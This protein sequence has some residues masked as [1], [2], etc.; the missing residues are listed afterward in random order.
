M[1]RL[2]FLLCLITFHLVIGAQTVNYYQKGNITTD[3]ITIEESVVKSTYVAPESSPFSF[4]NLTSKGLD[5]TTSAVEPA[6][7]LQNT[8]GVNMYSDNGTNLGYMYYRLRGIDQSRINTTLNGVPMNEPED[9]GIYFNNYPGF[10]QSVSSLQVIRG[11]GISKSGI[12][13]YGGSMNFQ[14]NPFGKEFGGDVNTSLGSYNTYQGSVSISDNNYYIRA[15]GVHTD[16]YKQNTF[17]NGKSMFYG[18]KFNNFKI[19]G[20][21]GDQQNGMGWLGETKEDLDLDPSFNSNKIHEQDDFTYVHN[22]LNYTNGNFSGT[23][24]HTYLNGWYDTD[25]AHFVPEL[26][27]GAVISRI[28]LESHWFGANLDYYIRGINGINAHLGISGST[29]FRDHVGSTNN[30]EDYT[31]TG[32]KKDLAPY[33]KMD[34]K[35]N[36]VLLYFDAQYRYTEFTYDGLTEFERKQYHFINWSGGATYFTGDNSNVYFGLGKTHR[37]PT[38]TD[39]FAGNDDFIPD[40]YVDVIPESSMDYELGYKYMTSKLR[41][42]GNLYYM[43][44]ENE[45]VLTG[46]YG[47]NAIS[48]HENVDNSYRSGIEID[49]SY[50]IC[51]YSQFNFISNFSKNEIKSDGVEFSPVLTPSTILTGEIVL[52]PCDYANIGF[53]VRYNSDSYIDLANEH[54]LPS[55]T[56]INAYVSTSYKNFDLRWNFDN[57]TNRHVLTNAVIGFDGDPRYFNMYGFSTLATLRYNF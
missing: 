36:N 45:I 21:I 22:Q 20:F 47:P 44:F 31:N 9:Q 8:P 24:Y 1:K 27:Y 35:Y 54:E 52:K 33:F 41:F 14:V 37:E 16:G 50:D 28:A 25:I 40:M 3:T 4:Y 7:I 15:T 53:S 23:L 10:M 57:V 34:Y 19:I 17:H 56:L 5:M 30:V 11:A 12:A 39:W 18:F 6:V 26:E 46:Q 55:Y 42:K 49:F 29:Y 2:L 51:D 13:S 48:L 32:Y 43:D 38:R